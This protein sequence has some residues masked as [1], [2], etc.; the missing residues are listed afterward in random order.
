MD[1]DDV[2]PP[3]PAPNVLC[4]ATVDQML[5]VFSIAHG[6]QMWRVKV[7]GKSPYAI[8]RVYHIPAVEDGLAAQEGIRRFVQEMV[9]ATNAVK[10]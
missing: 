3:A 6:L 1:I 8:T 4:Q 7:V 10:C 2:C 9:D 5:H